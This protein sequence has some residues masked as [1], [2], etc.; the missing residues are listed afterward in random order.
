MQEMPFGKAVL[1]TIG[2]IIIALSLIYGASIIGLHDIWVAFLALTV[3]GATGMKMEQAPGI[4][5]GAAYG[6]LLSLS[7]EALPD[8]YGAWAAII[9]LVLIILTISCQITGKLP[10]FCN[11][12]TFAFLTI[13]SADIILD[14]RLQLDYLPNLALGAVLFWILPWTILKLKSSGQQEAGAGKAE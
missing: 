8:L 7:V 11:F 3:W 10:L 12:S 1:L 9:P 2:I 4:F 13:G 5:I 6:L 14:Q